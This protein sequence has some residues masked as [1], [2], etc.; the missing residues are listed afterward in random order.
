MSAICFLLFS[1]VCT[2]YTAGTTS[3]SIAETGATHGN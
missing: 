3:K 1:L 2:I